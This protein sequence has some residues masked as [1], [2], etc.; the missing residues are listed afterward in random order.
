MPE[1]QQGGGGAAGGGG[2][3]GGGGACEHGPRGKHGLYY[4]LSIPKHDG[5]DHLGLC[6]NMDQK[7]GPSSEL[8]AQITS[9]VDHLGGGLHAGGKQPNAAGGGGAGSSP[10]KVHGKQVEAKSPPR[11]CIAP[12]SALLHSSP[13]GFLCRFMR[14]ADWKRRLVGS[15]DRV[16]ASL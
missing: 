15:A 11:A 7:H 6:K 12:A 4:Y 3:A 9:G 5:P 10:G 8:T 16:A 2:S 13:R 14:R 1:P